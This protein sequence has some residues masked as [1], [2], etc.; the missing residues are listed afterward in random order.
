MKKLQTSPKI[1]LYYIKYWKG[2]VQRMRSPLPT[3]IKAE[4]YFK[5]YNMVNSVVTSINRTKE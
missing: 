1:F 3:N 4:K 5:N 2:D